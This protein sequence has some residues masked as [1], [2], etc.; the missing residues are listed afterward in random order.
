M[1]SRRSFLK[2]AG[3]AGIAAVAGRQAGAFSG[4]RIPVQ[5][6]KALFVWGGWE[7]HEPEGFKNLMVP[8]MESNGFDVTVSDTLDAY[9]EEELM[10]AVDVIVQCWTMG[11]ISGDQSKALLD[12]VKNGA[13]FAGWHGG[14][15]DSFRQ[16]TEYQFMVGGQ[17]VA[18]PGGKIDYDVRIT[19]PNDEITTGLSDFHMPNT[20]Q[21][22]MHVDPNNHVLATTRFTDEHA[23]WL[24]GATCPVVWKRMYGEGRVFYNSIGHQVVDFDVSEARTITERGIVWASRSRV[25]G[26]ENWVSPAY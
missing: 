12:T 23:Y 11:E 18:H 2:V 25:E 5:D 10:A 4:G 1:T 19:E 20:E 6:K 22:Y 16:N 7:G 17:W 3:S 14:S 9:L 24:G 21:Y 26:P 13:G 15:G 8:W